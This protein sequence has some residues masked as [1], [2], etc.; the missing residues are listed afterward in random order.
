MALAAA[1]ELIG[2]DRSRGRGLLAGVDEAGRG[3]LAGP[4]VAAAVVC[5]FAD[6][7][8]RVRDSKLVP[9]PERETL[10]ER[11][12]RS[13]AAWSIGVAAP[14]EI[15]EV[16]IL[17]ATMRAM[18]RA[19]A[20]LSREPDLVL[21]DGNRLPALSCPA[22]TVTGGDRKSFV[23]AAASIVAKVS[24]D[25]MM[26]RWDRDYPGYGFPKH[27][28]YGTAAHREAIAKLGLSSLHR[29]SFRTGA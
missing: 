26:R 15:D 19:V 5:E 10:Y 25:R 29:K 13:A 14:A 20:G 17:V 3:A 24:R 2:F 11:I 12:V 9:E 4:V 22:E 16:N 23:I 6:G 18:G 21:V 7:L 8:E 28:G 1:S 27:K